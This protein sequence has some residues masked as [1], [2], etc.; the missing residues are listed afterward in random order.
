[1]T[2]AVIAALQEDVSSI[3]YCW[4]LTRADGVVL[5]FTS[6]D[7]DLLID[8]V[9]F[10]SR[11][12]MT[13]S[14]VTLSSGFQVNSMDVGGILDAASITSDDLAWGRWNDAVVEFFAANW[15]APEAGLL[16][17]MKGTIGDVRRHISSGK[18]TFE[19]ELISEMASLMTPSAPRCAPL[20]RANF[21]DRRCGVDVDALSVEVTLDRGTAGGFLVQG[22]ISGIGMLSGGRLRILSGPLSGVDRH[23]VGLDDQKLILEEALPDDAL[24]ARVRVW[25]GCD[26]RF[27]TCRQHYQNGAMFDGEPHVPGTDALV[28][29]GAF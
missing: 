1:M 7:H 8:G 28:R 25:P 26:K 15:E 9:V 21:G 29:Y 19:A 2:E 14:A 12:G 17:L 23:I 16:R 4:K 5:G 24:P 11:P 10:R 22:D 18:G 3:A 27:V 20:C 6:H 13:P